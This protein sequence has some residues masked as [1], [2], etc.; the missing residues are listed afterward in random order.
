MQFRSGTASR[1]KSW[2]ALV[3]DHDDVAGHW[4]D[5]S[6]MWVAGAICAD[7][8]D[9]GTAPGQAGTGETSSASRVPSLRGTVVGG[10]L[11]DYVSD[12]VEGLD[13][14]AFYAPYRG[15]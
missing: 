7:R 3:T 14:T 8:V 2:G 11:A 4:H 15:G 5:T 12:L 13:L 9:P 6:L 10:H 1:N